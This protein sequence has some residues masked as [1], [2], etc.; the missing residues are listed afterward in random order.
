MIAGFK[1]KPI[2]QA[3]LL[4]V[5]PFISGLV[6][7]TDVL[8]N[9]GNSSNDGQN[10]TETI[11]TP[12]TVSAGFG[13]LFS[14]ALDAAVVAQP[15]IKTGLNITTGAAAGVHDVVFV[16]TQALSLYALDANTGTVLWKTSLLHSFHGGTATVRGDGYHSVTDTPAIDPTLNV[17]YIESAEVENGNT[18][19]LLSSINIANG[20]NYAN[21]VNIAESTSVPAYVS[22]PTTLS[23]KKFNAFDLSSRTLT[24][25]PVNHVVYLGFGG[26]G[27]PVG[28]YNG[29]ILGYGATKD[30][31]GNL[32]LKAVWC[33]TP[34]GRFAGIW[35]GAGAIAV[36]ASGNLFFITGQGYFDTPLITAPYVANGRLTSLTDNANIPGGL[37]VPYMGNYADVVVKLTPDGDTSQQPDNPNGFG[38]HV[39]DYFC[40]KDE[41]N[42]Y[43]ADADL[44]SSSPILLPD[45]VGSTAHRQLLVI[46]DK[47]GI[48]Y[49]VDRN[50]MGGYHGNTAGDGTSGTNNMVQELD[51]ATHGA[52]CTGAFFAASSSTSG[53]IYYAT[54]K[55]G[56]TAGNGDVAKA[57]SISNATINPVPVS[58]SA[59]SYGA[60][61]YPGSTPAI[62]ANGSANGI[63]WTLDKTPNR[64]VAYDAANF[65]TVLFRSD[66]GPGN[67]L[68]GNII[69]FHTPT[70]A[71]GHVYVGTTTGLN[72]YGSV[73]GVTYNSWAA[74]AGL[75]GNAALPTAI[76]SHDGLTNLFKYALGLNPFTTYST[77]SLPAVEK[78]DFSGT[79]YLTLKFTGVAA[80]VTYSVQVTSDLS[81]AAN[82]KTIYTYK[83]SPAPG[84]VTVKDTQPVSDSPQRFMRLVIT[85]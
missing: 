1:L 68:T 25:N 69:T 52:W 2:L 73:A 56:E 42:L 37:R 36:D 32:P 40:P 29:W 62:S 18:I 11:L 77:S 74:A 34:N 16:G 7:A 21:P 23:G 54:A 67:A 20:S 5:S 65:N 79:Q 76:V 39:A 17:L 27:V 58:T 85:Q 63:L 82:W 30:V 47:Q 26:P 10:L 57:F 59:T 9:H 81:S 50:N 3:F 8:L 45:S 83:N 70:V 75:S 84:T 31:S 53:T 78:T 38:L 80:D 13:K 6:Y 46:N 33:A 41:A 60:Y 66:Q 44:G 49:L 72:V 48:I 22:G 15:L 4:A 55:Y 51:A 64:L 24:I 71:N 12:A 35:Q 61:S 14:V 43:N 28:D 19:H